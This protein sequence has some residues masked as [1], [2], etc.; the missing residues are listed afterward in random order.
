M[1]NIDTIITAHNRRVLSQDTTAQHEC[2]CNSKEN[3][4]LQGKCQETAI[5]Y[6]AT[7]ET[8]DETKKY[9]GITGGTFKQ[10]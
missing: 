8:N 7:V 1:K 10:L 2:N 4:P 5:V 6:Q 9:I 3:F